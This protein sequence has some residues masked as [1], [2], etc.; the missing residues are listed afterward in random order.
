[1]IKSIFTE[2]QSNIIRFICSIEF[3]ALKDITLEV[4]LGE[5][6]DEGFTH[7]ELLESV[8]CDRSDFDEA[9]I[10][11]YNQFQNLHENPN[12]LFELSEHDRIIFRQVLRL[13]ED[14]ISVR[15]PNALKNLWDKITII[16]AARSMMN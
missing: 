3:K 6:A 11:T 14:E 15:F 10:E 8:E 2:A 9:L 1:M 12:L 5:Y 4:E 13:Y 16:E 7:E